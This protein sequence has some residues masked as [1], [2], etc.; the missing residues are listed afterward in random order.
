MLC[1]VSWRDGSVNRGVC[2]ESC[3]YEL[4]SGLPQGRERELTPKNIHLIS[5]GVLCPPQ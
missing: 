2:V 1:F 5:T 4:G 3:G